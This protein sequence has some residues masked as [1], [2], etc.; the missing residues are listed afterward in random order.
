[1]LSF[2]FHLVTTLCLGLVRFR[3]KSHLANIRKRSRFVLKH[4][5]WSPQTQL[6]KTSVFCYHSHSWKPSWDLPL[7]NVETH[8][9]TGHW[10]Y[11]LL[12]WNFTT[13]PSTECQYGMT[14]ANV[15]LSGVCIKVNC[16]HFAP[17]TGLQLQNVTAI[18]LIFIILGIF[19]SGCGFIIWHCGG[20]WLC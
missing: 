17:E 9:W 5:L 20:W 2:K 19:W 12:T 18:S 16:Q 15:N 8:S 3:D 10:L 6:S 7:T 4:L 11:S 13:I 1:M 14:H